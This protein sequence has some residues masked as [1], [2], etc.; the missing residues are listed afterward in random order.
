MAI[1]D[2]FSR[3]KRR[4]QGKF[5]DV[6]QYDDIPDALRVQVVHIWISTYGEAREWSEA[7]RLFHEMHETLCREYGVFNLAEEGALPFYKVSN[8][9]LQSNETDKVLDVIELTFRMLDSVVRSQPNLFTGT[10]TPAE[11]IVELNER[12]REHGVGYQY[13]SGRMI[14]IDSQLVHSEVVIPAL[15]FLSGSKFTGANQE[16]LSA[17]GHYREGKHKECLNDCLKAFESTM[18]AICAKRKWAFNPNGT[19]KSLIEVLFRE[20]LIPDFMQSHFSALRTTLE[21]GVP[22]VRNKLG[23]HGQGVDPVIVP[24]YLASYALHLTATNILLIA[25]AEAALP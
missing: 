5:P 16:F 20:N 10:T 21:A 15:K 18:K 24:E 19:A 3:R 6:Y 17:H 7:N 9:M 1:F 4:E 14:R 2:L 13:E 8:F 12:F 25:Q 23:G 11:S 22:T